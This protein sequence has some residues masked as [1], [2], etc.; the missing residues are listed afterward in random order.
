MTV[1]R[2]SSVPDVP[3]ATSTAIRIP[4][5]K[6]LLPPVLRVS[7]GTPPA[8]LQCRQ[9]FRIVGA[10]HDRGAHAVPDVQFVIDRVVGTFSAGFCRG[11]S[12]GRTSVTLTVPSLLAAPMS[13]ASM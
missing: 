8:A 7:F 4:V 13:R 10:R 3:G 2:L 5:P 11:E 12:S 6:E 1:T 9:V